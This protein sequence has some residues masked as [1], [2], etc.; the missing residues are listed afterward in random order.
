MV[1]RQLSKNKGLLASLS[2]TT[3]IIIIN[4]LVFI[5]I[6]ILSAIYGDQLIYSYFALMP[7]NFM[8]GKY[9][10]TVITHMFLHANLLH[11]L[12]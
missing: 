10:W 7:Q 5:V 9:L 6:S 4:V 11:L 3:K 2:I 8:A 12:F 1:N